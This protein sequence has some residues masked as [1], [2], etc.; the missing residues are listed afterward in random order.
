[1]SPNTEY[2]ESL[3][4]KFNNGSISADELEVLKEWYVSHDD[5][6]VIITSERD[7]SS[8]EVKSRILAGLLSKVADKEARSAKNFHL[9]RW[10]VATAAVLLV[11]IGTWAVLE[12]KSPAEDLGNVNAAFQPGGNK[13]TLTLANGRT[14]ALSNSQ[15]GIVTGEEITYTNGIPVEDISTDESGDAQSLLALHTPRG[16][17]YKITLSDGTE[18]W[19]NAASTI[20]YPS[21]FAQDKRIVELDGEAY[22]SVKPAY[23]KNGDKIPFKVI[24][25]RQEVEVVGTQFNMAAYPEQGADKTTLVEGKV[26]V[27]DKQSRF[28]LVP[29]EQAVTTTG[30]TFVKKVDVNNYVA[31][32]DGK[33]SFDGKTFEETMEEIGR[34]YDLD[35]VYE[36]GI[37]K[38]E[39]TGDAFRNQNFGLVLR[40]LD[41]AEVD[42]KLD[43]E[44]R[45]LTIKGKKNKM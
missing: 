29:N 15:A 38:E 9:V 31:W 6:H 23:Q 33:F 32:R 1:M 21:R 25:K 11:A 44:R 27:N 7:E 2:I 35:I 16:G 22:F 43:V 19:L 13:A 20:K 40:L 41:V 26:V 10:I 34:W 42:Y 28:I 37:P 8:D 30:K 14:I 18:V 5:Q 17:T 39:L 12:N 45:K 3:V 24:S 4:F 36:S